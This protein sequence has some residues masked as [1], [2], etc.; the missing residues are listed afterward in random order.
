MYFIINQKNGITKKEEKFL[1][2]FLNKLQLMTF[3]NIKL[4]NDFKG[5]KANETYSAEKN[6]DKYTV[7][8]DGDQITGVT[9]D[10]LVKEEEQPKQKSQPKPK[11]Q[12]KQEV[13]ET[14]VEVPKKRKKVSSLQATIIFLGLLF[15]L[16]V[17]V[18]SCFNT[19]IEKDPSDNIEIESTTIVKNVKQEENIDLLSYY[20]S[21][22]IQNSR[23]EF[24]ANGIPKSVIAK[25][26]Y[27]HPAIKNAAKQKLIEAVSELKM[28]TR[29]NMVVLD[30]FDVNLYNSNESYRININSK[31]I[32]NGK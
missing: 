30:T 21:E 7:W 29:I 28:N 16:F 26:D 15:F 17:F 12:V 27:R 1:L 3:V 5:L 4:N 10:M 18:R 13:E 8:A 11:A 31:I 19:S 23:L 14:I 25:I 22:L 2:F 6:N 32:A 20:L 9:E 24:E